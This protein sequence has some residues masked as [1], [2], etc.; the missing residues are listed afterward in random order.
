MR[1][2]S[3]NGKWREDDLAKKIRAKI[4]GSVAARDMMYYDTDRREI[5]CIFSELY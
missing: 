1:S 3:G 4:A 5:K 2:V